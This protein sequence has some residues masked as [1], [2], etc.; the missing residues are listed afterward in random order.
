MFKQKKSKTLLSGNA[1]LR[2]S[3]LNTTASLQ[4][5][6]LTVRLWLIVLSDFMHTIKKAI[7]VLYE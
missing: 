1:S 2:H 5:S 3:R 4:V 7:I 6:T